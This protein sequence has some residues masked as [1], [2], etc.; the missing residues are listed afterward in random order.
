M[1]MSFVNKYDDWVRIRS[2]RI[3]KAMVKPWSPED[4][5]STKVTSMSI[6]Y[7]K[8]NTKNRRLLPIVYT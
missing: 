8:L 4:Y 5:C 6:N 7:D 1:I 2:N 3:K